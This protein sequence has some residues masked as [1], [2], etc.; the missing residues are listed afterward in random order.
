[1]SLKIAITQINATVGD[2][3]GNAAKILDFARRASAQ[4]A[5]LLLTPELALCGHSPEDLLLREDFHAACAQEL[6]ALT[7]ALPEI[8]VLIGHPLRQDG[9]CFNAAGLLRAGRCVALISYFVNPVNCIGCTACARVCPVDCIEGSVKQ[10]HTIIQ[11]KCIK[12]GSCMAAC[13]FDAIV[14]K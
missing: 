5:D 13:K 8:D 3:A 11:D 14:K 10:V 12:C 4:G 1:M 7:A 6:A 2:L 9:R